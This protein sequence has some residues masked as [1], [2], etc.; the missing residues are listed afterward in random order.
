[1]SGYREERMQED[2]VKNGPFS[3]THL[4]LAMKMQEKFELFFITPKNRQSDF[5]S[6]KQC[7]TVN[8]TP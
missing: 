7:V 5:Y 1:M 8:R 6:I 4:R 3:Y 2:T